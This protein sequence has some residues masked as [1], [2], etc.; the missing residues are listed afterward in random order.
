MSAAPKPYGKILQS[1]RRSSRRYPIRLD[2]V[3]KLR[4]GSRF[5]QRG[6]GQTLNLSSRGVLFQSES[7]LPLGARIELCIAW[8]VLLN[9]EAA[10]NLFVTGQKVRGEGAISA[11][12]IIRYVFRVRSRRKGE[13]GQESSLF[14]AIPRVEPSPDGR[15][16]PAA[17]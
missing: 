16:E 5:V 10:L 11:I 6:T 17:G 12:R 13:L 8:P 14:P 1:D 7:E 4:R 15:T 9:E 2:V 3:F